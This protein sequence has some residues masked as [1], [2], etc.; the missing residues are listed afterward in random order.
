LHVAKQLSGT[1]FTQTDRFENQQA[2]AY[3]TFLS[4]G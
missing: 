4:T 1:S 2:A 3:V